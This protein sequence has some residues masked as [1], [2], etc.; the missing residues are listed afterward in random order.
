MQDLTPDVLAQLETGSAGFALLAQ[1]VFPEGNFGLWTGRGTLT[2]NAF[3]YRG[4]DRFLQ[5]GSIR[6]GSGN[7]IEGS[8]LT[9][10]NVPSDKL[11]PDWLQTIESYS[12]SNAPC[13]ISVLVMDPQTCA[14]KGLALFAPFEID[15]L[16]PHQSAV[17]PE[18]GQ[19]EVSIEV[20]LETPSRNIRGATYFK[21]SLADQQA[22]N[23]P[24]DTGLR[25]AVTGN[26]FKLEFGRIKG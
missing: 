15:T 24:N 4:V 19:R 2:W 22:M 14:V 26:R 12:Y 17:D 21:R 23:N 3:D 13:N 25:H 10:A 1:F 9:M 16:V 18:T 11:D 7:T 20:S 8:T 6:R 5:L